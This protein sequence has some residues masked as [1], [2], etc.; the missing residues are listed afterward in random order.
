MAYVRKYKDGSLKFPYRLTDLKKD[1]PNVSFNQRPSDEDLAKYGIYPV[2]NTPQPDYEP[3][4]EE[5]QISAVESSP[6]VWEEAW[7]VVPRSYDPA[8]VKEQVVIRVKARARNL[9]RDTAGVEF[10]QIQLIAE[11]LKIYRQL[12]NDLY[13]KAGFRPPSGVVSRLEEIKDKVLVLDDYRTAAR[14]I[15]SDINAMPAEEAA[16]FDIENDPRWP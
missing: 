9:A 10:E 16:R 1:F 14:Q 8:Q 7:T 15:V 4:I 12:F 11:V 13:T 5:V 6:G 3:L 2:S